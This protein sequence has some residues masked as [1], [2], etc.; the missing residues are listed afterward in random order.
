MIHRLPRMALSSSCPLLPPQGG[1][2]GASLESSRCRDRPPDT[3]IWFSSLFPADWARK[4]SS[5]LFLSSLF[6][7]AGRAFILY[8]M[9]SSWAA[10]L[11]KCAPGWAGWWWLRADGKCCGVGHARSQR[12]GCGGEKGKAEQ[13]RT[14]SESLARRSH[15]RVQVEDGEARGAA[16]AG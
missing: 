1:L 13:W 14:W 5:A 4:E 10:S 6:P 11:S 16:L 12:T 7:V 15:H 9:L 8:R 2:L 3:N